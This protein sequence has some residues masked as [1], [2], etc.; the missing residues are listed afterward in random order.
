[1][2]VVKRS[3][4]HLPMRRTV[5]NI[6]VANTHTYFVGELGLWVHNK[7]P[8]GVSLLPQVAQTSIQNLGVS[9]EKT[10]PL[11]IAPDSAKGHL[12]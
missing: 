7:N 4:G 2:S 1:M 8:S 11:V 5:Y 12:V 6:E 9:S 10:A 3:G